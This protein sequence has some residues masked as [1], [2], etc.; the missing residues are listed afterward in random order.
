MEI[1]TPEVRKDMARKFIEGPRE[2][3]QDFRG[4][5]GGGNRYMAAVLD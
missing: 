1:V 3:E 5:F 4:V 2:G